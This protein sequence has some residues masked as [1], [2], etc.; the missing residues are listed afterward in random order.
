MSDGFSGIARNLGNIYKIGPNGV[1][2]TFA[3]GLNGPLGLA[4]DSAGNLFVASFGGTILKFTPG[5][6][7]S[8]FAIGLNDP[9]GL[10]FDSAGNLFVSDGGSILEFSPNGAL[11][12]F[13]SGFGRAVGLAFDSAGNLFQRN[14]KE[15]VQGLVPVGECESV[16]AP[17]LRSRIDF[18]RFNESAANPKTF[19][20]T[21]MNYLETN[22][23]IRTAGPTLLVKCNVAFTGDLL[24][25]E[26][27]AP[28]FFAQWLIGMAFFSTSLSR[29]ARFP[30]RWRYQAA[31]KGPTA[32]CCLRSVHFALSISDVR[33]GRI[34]TS[35]VLSAV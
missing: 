18:G 26:T 9:E 6:S 14:F 5:G 31:D 3:S 19:S 27:V 33:Y 20:A 12:I 32:F 8:T 17:N 13:A 22:S 29:S 15:L 21:N 23:G 7:R 30:T 34:N 10:A 35:A 1:P 24:I 16:R 11:T 4:F 25:I 28:K 2:S